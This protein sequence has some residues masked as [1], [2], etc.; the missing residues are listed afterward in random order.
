VVT[1][2]NPNAHFSLSIGVVSLVSP[3]RWTDWNRVFSG[4]DQPFQLGP[5]ETALAGARVDEGHF[6]V[7]GI[8][9]ESAL[10][11]VFAIVSRSAAVIALP[12]PLILPVSS[13]ARI[14]CHDIWRRVS[15]RGAPTVLEAL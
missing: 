5:L 4:F 7:A 10:P 13:A 11:M 14:D 3:A 12:T 9:C 6:A 15:G 8:V 1:P 2:G